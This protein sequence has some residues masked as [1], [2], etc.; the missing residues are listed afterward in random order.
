VTRGINVVVLKGRRFRI[1][2]ALLE[3]SGDCA[4]CSQIEGLLGTGGYNAVRGHGGITARII[5]GGLVTIGDA[6]V[7]VG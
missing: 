5:E 6:V 3:G 7:V 4:P 2:S 1:G